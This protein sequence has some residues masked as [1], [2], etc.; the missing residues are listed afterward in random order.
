VAGKN[1]ALLAAVT[2][3][4]YAMAEA[5]DT[6]RIEADAWIER[7]LIEHE[8]DL[9]ESIRA[10]LD[11]GHSIM[12]VARAYTTSGVETPNRNAVYRLLK[13][14]GDEPVVGTFP[15]EWV[16]RKVRTAAGTKTVYDVHATLNGY[17]PQEVSG[18]FTW[19]Y[20]LGEL[21]PVI[22]E[23]DPYPA[24]VKYYRQALEKWHQHNPYPGG[25]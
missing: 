3:K 25:E 22:T 16:P 2:N 14:Y 13:K 5:Q 17:G 19:R 23:Q 24:D 7:K 20:L 8:R 9:L 12:A 10:A 4:V 15:F 18:D 1:Q 11:D 21:D 6:L